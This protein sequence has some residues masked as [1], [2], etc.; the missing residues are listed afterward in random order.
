MGL[1]EY[2]ASALDSFCY[3]V[4]P[5]QF[6]GSETYRHA[7]A[8]NRQAD[9]LM[10]WTK[11]GGKVPPGRLVKRREKERAVYFGG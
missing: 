11:A 9:A 3:N 4:G 10:S 7:Q 8:S 5:H 2:Q 1:A 6:I